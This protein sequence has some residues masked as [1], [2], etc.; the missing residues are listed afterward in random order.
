MENPRVALLNIGEEA[1]KGSA[2][3]KEAYALMSGTPVNFTGNIE[4]REVFMGE[5]DVVVTDGF[6]GNIVLKVVE[7]VG[8][9]L[10]G[11]LKDGITSSVRAKAG[12]ILLKPVLMDIRRNTDPEETGGAVLLGLNSL[13]V[14]AH[15]SS[16]AK[17]VRNAI[18]VAVK[19][20]ENDVVGHIKQGAA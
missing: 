13:C 19:A 4:G 14:I 20:V 17:A 6:T 10:L 1:E 7:G 11:A 12:G 3:T 15:G 9:S 18:G 5:A 2:F 16:S 8:A